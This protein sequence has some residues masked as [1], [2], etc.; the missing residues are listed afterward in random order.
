MPQPTPVAD[1]LAT[2]MK[3]LGSNPQDLSALI[4]AGEL[5]AQLDD[6]AAALQFFAR[7]EKVS[8]GDARIAR[9]RGRA[10]VRLGRPGEALRQFALAEASGL[11]PAD[12]A[13]DRGLAYDLIGQPR[14]AQMEYARALAVGEDDEV[15]RRYA[16]SQ[17]ISGDAAAAAQTLD[18]QLRQ[19]DRAGWRTKALT[20]AIG[21]DLPAAEKVAVEM[22]PGFGTAYIPLFRRLS[23]I[24]DPADRAFAAHLGEFTRSPVRMADITMAPPLPAI[25]APPAA[26][27]VRLA[28]AP[29]AGPATRAERS[30]PATRGNARTAS[31]DRRVT[32]ASARRAD[33]TDPLNRSRRNESAVVAE[34]APQGQALAAVPVTRMAANTI[35]AQPVE[36]APVQPQPA[37]ATPA[38]SQLA[39]APPVSTPP[40]S[41]PPASTVA[42]PARMAANDALRPTQGILPS[43]GAGQSTLATPVPAASSPVTSAAARLPVPVAPETQRPAMAAASP[44]PFV[45][46]SS[47]LPLSTARAVP[48]PAAA[49]PAAASASRPAERPRGTG[50]ESNI[51]AAIVARIAVPASELGVPPMPSA[52][53]PTAVAASVASARAEAP[54]P[55]P[56]VPAPKR[57]AAKPE[58][59]KPETKKPEVKK[60]AEKPAAKPAPKPPAEPS[61]HWVQVAGGANVND[62]PKAWSAIAAKAPAM[63]KSRTAWTTPLRATN[64][65]LTG[66]FESAGAAQAFVNKLAGEDVSAFVFTSEAGQKIAKLPAK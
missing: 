56:V 5:S 30:S 57:E 63:L 39:A 44:A 49:A 43:P 19:R 6:G 21:G 47:R 51:L 20:L 32:A 10:L 23:E 24:R 27:P 4:R 46:A 60:P 66:P 29:I 26:T 28:E 65:L 36:A 16:I 8:R 17:A 15:R 22:M 59:V 52:P 62:L 55:K 25:A 31:R 50:A 18:P 37:Q 64:R 2:T 35:A 13:G 1:Q 58:T 48:P 41:T 3:A 7:A 40:V 45:N 11:A 33:R 34:V 9:G 12:Y 42:A 53:A 38:A 14:H 54:T 61:R